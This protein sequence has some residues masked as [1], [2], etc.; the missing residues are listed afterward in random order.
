MKQAWTWLALIGAAAIAT[1]AQAAEPEPACTL[2][3]QLTPELLGWSMLGFRD[4]AATPAALAKASLAPGEAVLGHMAPSAE[5]H[6][7]RAPEKPAAP[8]TYSGMWQI[9]TRAA[10]TWRV[11]LGTRAWIDV[12]GADGKS[13]ASVAHSMGPACT[14]I[15]KMVDFP[16]STGTWTIQI[17]GSPV[18]DG[19][20]MVIPAPKP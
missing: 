14:G 4:A 9:A 13:V 2:P 1:R 8:G 12:V 20:V 16:L 6:L 15:R 19:I 11:V 18:R 3:G 10:G 5:V 17:T 7:V